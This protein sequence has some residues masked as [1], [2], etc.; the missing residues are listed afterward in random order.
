MAFIKLKSKK[1]FQVISVPPL[2]RKPKMVDEPRQPRILL[3]PVPK[4]IFIS[5]AHEDSD[6]LEFLIGQATHHQ[7]L[8]EFV[9]MR[10]K[11]PDSELWKSKCE[12]KIKSCAGLIVLVSDRTVESASQ[13]WEV[14]CAKQASVPTLGVFCKSDRIPEGLP[15]EFEAVRLVPWTWSNVEQFVDSLPM[16]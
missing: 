8:L 14:E 12:A 15:K 16:T 3:N 2:A 13:L 11:I 1:Q 7:Y 9:G 5:F 6:Y 10:R 4:R